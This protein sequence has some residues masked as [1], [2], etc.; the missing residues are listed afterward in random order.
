MVQHIPFDADGQTNILVVE[1]D[2]DTRGLF[3]DLLSSNGY[4]PILSASGEE[5]LGRLDD[6]EVDLVVLDLR[7]PGMSGYEVCEQVRSTIGYDM[8]ILMLTANHERQGAAEG[9]RLG[10]DDYVRKPFDPDELLGRIDTLRRRQTRAAALVTENEALRQTLERVQ[11][12]MTQAIALSDTEMTLRR[13]YSHNVAIHLRALCGVIEGEY[14][15]N[16][17]PEVREVVQRVLS[18]TRGVALV[19]ETSDLLQ[20][21]PADVDALIRT[22][23]LALKQIYSPRQRI[24]LTVEGDL[25]KIPLQRAAPLAIMVNE[26]VT[27]CFKHAF[28]GQRFGA[29]AIRY[30]LVDQQFEL[31]VRDDGVGFPA[32]STKVGR[33][34]PTVEQLATQLG[35]GA[36]WES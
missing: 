21:D 20:E 11:N 3:R 30:G 27:N 16:I 12:E 33:G 35:G 1:D 29:V 18:R 5:G 31:C 4:R 9:F 15:R 32:E 2:D 10:A 13:E 17:S 7:L 25:V 8:P 26:L 34:R 6:H 36:A 28:P 24:P 19:Y 23:G 22:I 14:R